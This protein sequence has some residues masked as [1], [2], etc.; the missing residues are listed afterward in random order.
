MHYFY[1]Q[2]KLKSLDEYITTLKYK[3]NSIESDDTYK[4]L[5]QNKYN[6]KNLELIKKPQ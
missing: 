6:I 4:Y 1:I 2:A 3:Y 5:I